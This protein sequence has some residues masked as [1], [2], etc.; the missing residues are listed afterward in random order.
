MKKSF[1][2]EFVKRSIIKW[3]SRN[4]WGHFEFEDS[5]SHGVDIK[6]RKGGR[7]I[8]IETKGESQ[9]RSGNEVNFVYGLGQLVTRMKVVDAPRAFNYVLGVPTSVARLAIK[10]IPWKFAKKLTVEV[11][12]V[13]SDGKVKRYTWQDL[14]IAQTDKR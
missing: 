2:E 4:G 7:V 8:F 12:A 1:S 10:R 6:A 9:N 13:S 3:L 5:R 14:R 11:F